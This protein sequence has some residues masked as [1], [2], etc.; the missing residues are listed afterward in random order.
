MSIFRMVLSE[1]G[2][3]LGAIAWIQCTKDEQFTHEGGYV[4]VLIESQAARKGEDV[5]LEKG[6]PSK[7]EIGRDGEW[8]SE[9]RKP[10]Y[11]RTNWR[12]EDK[13]ANRQIGTRISVNWTGVMKQVMTKE[14]K[15]HWERRTKRESQREEKVERQQARKRVPSSG[16]PC[17]VMNECR[18]RPRYSYFST[19]LLFII[20]FYSDLSGDTYKRQL[21]VLCAGTNYTI[22]YPSER[23]DPLHRRI[24]SSK[25]I[26]LDGN[27]DNN[28]FGWL[29][30]VKSRAHASLRR[31]EDNLKWSPVRSRHTESACSRNA[32]HS[33]NITDYCSRQYQGKRE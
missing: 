10:K 28:W 12:N 20:L 2:G 11:K 9:D 22:K 31:T 29:Y 7:R 16:I 3:W 21:M 23:Y 33:G 27:G 26:N 5:R 30:N 15:L 17:A 1:L 32:E 25:D 6:G 18:I 14:K 19:W 8:Q 24:D 4:S 13:D